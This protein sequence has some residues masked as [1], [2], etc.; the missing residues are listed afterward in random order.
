[1]M[2]NHCEILSEVGLGF[3]RINLSDELRLKKD[4]L[5]NLIPKNWSNNKISRDRGGVF[6]AFFK[7]T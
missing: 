7:I 6:T 3:K 5:G 2:Q 4:F 1:M